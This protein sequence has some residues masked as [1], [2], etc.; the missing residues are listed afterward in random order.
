MIG[1][2]AEARLE[3][4]DLVPHIQNHLAQAQTLQANWRGTAGE[5]G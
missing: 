3:G 4:I 1:R 5:R 2:A